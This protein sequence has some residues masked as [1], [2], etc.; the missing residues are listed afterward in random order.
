M[1]RST[2]V[3]LLAVAAAAALATPAAAVTCPTAGSSGPIQCYSGFAVPTAA[4]GARAR[5]SGPCSLKPSRT[6][7]LFRLP[8]SGRSPAA[9]VLGCH[10][11][12][13]LQV[14]LLGPF[15]R[16]IHTPAAA[17]P[18]GVSLRKRCQRQWPA[19]ART[20]A[21]G[22]ARAPATAFHLATAT[23]WPSSC[24]NRHPPAHRR[25]RRVHGRM[26]LSM[27]AALRPARA[28]ASNSTC[29]VA[30]CRSQFATQCGTATSVGPAF[31]SL[32][33]IGYNS[34]TAAPA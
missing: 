32:S 9:G 1:A 13:W 12:E 11:A 19:R 20:Q 30:A 29:T 24:A 8:F 7:L 10:V 28:Q 18:V 26:R 27:R 2:I 23:R 34:A 16:A 15:C 21:R 31:A 6:T 17:G 25:R 3:L 22:R 5:V 14:G 4:A 33:S